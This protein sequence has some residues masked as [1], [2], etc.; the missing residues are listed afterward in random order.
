[1]AVTFLKACE[2]LVIVSSFFRHSTHGFAGSV[3]DVC[4]SVSPKSQSAETLH[5]VQMVIMKFVDG[6]RSPLV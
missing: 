6:F 3:G 2:R 1:M 4:F 5:L